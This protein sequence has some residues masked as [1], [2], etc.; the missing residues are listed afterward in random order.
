[1]DNKFKSYERKTALHT[2]HDGTNFVSI[3]NTGKNT[4]QKFH[5]KKIPLAN[6]KKTAT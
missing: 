1:M 5:F 6:I 2:R 3:T 4:S